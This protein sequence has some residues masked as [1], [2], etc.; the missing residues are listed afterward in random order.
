MALS[1][2]GELKTAIADWQLDAGAEITPQADVIVTL[3]RVYINMRLR[4][5]DMITV[6]TPT[7]TSAEATL[8]TDFIAPRRVVFTSGRRIVL[9]PM[10]PEQA[11]DWY[12]YR[13][14]GVPQHF[15]IIGNKLRLYPSP[16]DA[17]TVELTYYASIAEMAA[18]E[19]TDWL[20]TKYPNI[21][22]AAGQMYAAEYLKEDTEAQKQAAI[23]DMLIG[24]VN[25]Q[26]EDTDLSMGEFVP[27]SAAP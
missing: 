4:A 17:T 9:K 12:P 27:E 3:A 1:N 15:T 8:P 18:D 14:S 13:P 6:A 19:N 20:L 2:K 23:T 24:M 7:I 25:A 16:D 21:Y 22:L 11:D 26:D 5:R 10:T